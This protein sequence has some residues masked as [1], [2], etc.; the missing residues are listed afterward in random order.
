MIGLI[1]TLVLL[2]FAAVI[3]TDSLWWGLGV[4]L[5]IILA[6]FSVTWA[7]IV[8]VLSLAFLFLSQRHL[9]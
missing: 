7:F 6:M 8:L 9:Q 3:A 2:Y 4:V 1:I 5:F